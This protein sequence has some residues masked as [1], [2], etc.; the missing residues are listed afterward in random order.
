MRQDDGGVSTTW[1]CFLREGE[2]VTANVVMALLAGFALVC[3]RPV[4][5]SHPA[6]CR[7]AVGPA[8]AACAHREQPAIE[9][10]PDRPVAAFALKYANMLWGSQ[11]LAMFAHLSNVE[12]LA[13]PQVVAW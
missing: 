6:P 1:L 5:H 7:A 10:L 13:D 4:A 2:F 8:R 3:Y 9:H 12:K 11:L